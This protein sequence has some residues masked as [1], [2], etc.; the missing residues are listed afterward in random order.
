[1]ALVFFLHLFPFSFP[2]LP[3]GVLSIL[4][5][6][7]CALLFVRRFLILLFS[8]KQI[9]SKY[10]IKIQHTSNTVIYVGPGYQ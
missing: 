8:F 2:L 4:L 7:G 10:L 3:F 5:Y 6:L 9:L 1:M